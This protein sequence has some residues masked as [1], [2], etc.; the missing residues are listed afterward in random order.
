MARYLRSVGFLGFVLLVLFALTVPLFAHHS[1][2][3]VYDPNHKINLVGTV[4]KVKLDE[5]AHRH[6]FRCSGSGTQRSDG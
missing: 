6:F 4:T 3:S 5:S 1:A 2:A